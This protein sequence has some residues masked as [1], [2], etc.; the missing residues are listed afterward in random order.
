[1]SD[2]LQVEILARTSS[3]RQS[4][5]RQAR[6]GRGSRRCGKT[7]QQCCH[8]NLFLAGRR[9]QPRCLDAGDEATPEWDAFLG[10]I[11][12]STRAFPT[13]VRRTLRRLPIAKTYPRHLNLLEHLI[14]HTLGA[15]AIWQHIGQTPPPLS[16]NLVRRAPAATLACCGPSHM[17]PSPGHS[18]AHKIPGLPAESFTSSSHARSRA[19]TG[20]RARASGCPGAR[21][22]AL[23][24]GPRPLSAPLPT[25]R[26]VCISV[27]T[28]YTGSFANLPLC[29]GK[30]LGPGIS[31]SVATQYGRPRN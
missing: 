28:T 11:A 21:H 26:S 8:A 30:D 31:P 24:H 13:F 23:R 12:N 20:S 19:H 5:F 25:F 3:H 9:L 18:V 15:L 22:A 6:P 4:C 1:L 10:T 27:R 2:R 16:H 7:T 17:S 14:M 29:G